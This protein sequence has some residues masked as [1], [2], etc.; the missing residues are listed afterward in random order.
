MT[1]PRA[2][3]TADPAAKLAARS[4]ALAR[5]SQ[6][7]SAR[8]PTAAQALLRRFMDALGASM[9]RGVTVSLFWPMGDEIDVRPLMA[10]LADHGTVLALPVMQGRDKPL[11]F[12]RWQPGDE[13]ARAIFGVDE[14]LET[15]PE[16][17]PDIV[18]VPLLSFDGEG[19]R[20]GY[21]GGYYDRTLRKL[22]AG[23]VVLAVGVA[24][25]EQKADAVPADPSD[26][27]LDMVVTDRR[28]Y[29]FA[30][31]A[32]GGSGEETE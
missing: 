5:R 3:R 8:G 22:R 6:A 2:D 14:P 31:A 15:A 4:R 29:D 25:D 12:R 21:G 23:G 7:H 28:I 17:R 32:G 26:Q 30:P 18:V 11:L 10:V 1:A 27:P 24:Y 19:N 9:G 13:L 16:V 20:L